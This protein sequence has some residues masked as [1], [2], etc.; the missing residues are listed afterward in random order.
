MARHSNN[1][2]VSNAYGVVLKAKLI[3]FAMSFAFS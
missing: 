3:A 1:N 2:A